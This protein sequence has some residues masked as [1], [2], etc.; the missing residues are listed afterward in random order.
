MSAPGYDGRRIAHGMWVR[1]RVLRVRGVAGW[2]REPEVVARIEGWLHLE[3]RPVDVVR[4]AVFRFAR[5]WPHAVHT[6]ADYNALVT[7]VCQRAGWDGGSTERG[8]RIS[9][10]V[11]RPT[12][13]VRADA[14]QG[15][16][17][18]VWTLPEVFARRERRRATRARA[19][20]QRM[21][22][23]RNLMNAERDLRQIQ[24]SLKAANAA[25]R[26]RTQS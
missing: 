12:A 22:Q 14:L 25:L 26:E 24:H 6:V 3:A 8:A 19:E 9:P 11:C 21:A 2:W 7:R 5:R 18:P 10:D 1:Q 13:R 4:T 17:V 20:A 23:V 16:V 15:R